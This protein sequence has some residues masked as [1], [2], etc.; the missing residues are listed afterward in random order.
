MKNK[1]FTFTFV[2]ICI[3]ALPV[4]QSWP[5]HYPKFIPYRSPVP[6]AAMTLPSP[7]PLASESVSDS[8]EE[9]SSESPVASSSS[10]SS[11]LSNETS[12]TE[13]SVSS[14]TTS[15]TTTS[16][17][18]S[19]TVAPKIQVVVGYPYRPNGPKQQTTNRPNSS[20]S[21]TR[22]LSSMLRSMR[23]GFEEFTSNFDPDIER[24]IYQEQDEDGFEKLTPLV[25]IKFKSSYPAAD[26]SGIRKSS[27]PL[28]K[29]LSC[30]VYEDPKNAQDRLKNPVYA[31]GQTRKEIITNDQM[32]LLL[33]KCP[34]YVLITEMSL[35]K[36]FTRRCC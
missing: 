20:S 1:N 15:S 27:P 35:R 31:R 22:R 33:S 26:Q 32:A 13:S 28:P 34:R 18:T 8:L 17:T 5:H 12:S 7:L 36:L 29:I 9:T 2:V 21:F 4:S 25:E 14:S 16:T 3:A 10:S 24:V 11:L 23:Q 30:R 6:T 19:T